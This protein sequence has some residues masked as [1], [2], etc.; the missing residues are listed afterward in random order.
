MN[1]SPK[2]S[3]NELDYKKILTGLGI[4]MAGAAL[5]YIQDL[6]PTIDFGVWTPVVVALNSSLVNAA[7]RFVI[8]V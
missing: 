6:I 7:R 2:L 8:G 4:A 3:L 5:T 1:P